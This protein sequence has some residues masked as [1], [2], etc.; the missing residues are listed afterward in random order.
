MAHVIAALLCSL[1]VFTSLHGAASERRLGE[2]LAGKF[3]GFFCFVSQTIAYLVHAIVRQKR[4]KN[5]KENT[6][7][8]QHK[9]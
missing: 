5:E 8:R 4:Q 9:S 1:M 6:Q 3:I 2:A 7:Y